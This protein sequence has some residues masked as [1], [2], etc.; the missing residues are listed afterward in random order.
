MGYLIRCLLYDDIGFCHIVGEHP[1]MVHIPYIPFPYPDEILGS[2]LAR[3]YLH[4][5]RGTWVKLIEEAGYHQKIAAPLFDMVTYTEKLGRLLVVL[6][7]NYEKAIIDLT[8]LPYWLSFEAAKTGDGVLP[9]TIDIPRLV[10]SF[11]GSQELGITHRGLAC[12]K[13]HALRF[14]YCA[15]CLKYDYAST[16]EVYWHRAHQLPNTFFCHHH[17]C[18]LATSCPKCGLNIGVPST[19][20]TPLPR[21]VCACGY[22]L[23][24]MPALGTR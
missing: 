24:R 20:L 11:R 4:L 7:T 22:D 10:N 19:K 6:G 23:R 21:L 2:W 14:R 5:G 16:G 13:G 17:L 12:M 9:G 1:I 8:T 18:R 15:A 3:V